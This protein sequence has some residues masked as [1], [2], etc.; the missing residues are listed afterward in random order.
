MK[1]RN[2][3]PPRTL[4]KEERREPTGDKMEAADTEDWVGDIERREWRKSQQY[5]DATKLLEK[6]SKKK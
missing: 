1:K 6:W 4:S 5:A 2:Q 3:R